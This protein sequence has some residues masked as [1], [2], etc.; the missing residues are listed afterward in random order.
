MSRLNKIK[1]SIATANNYGKLMVLI[2]LLVGIPLIILP[3]YPEEINYAPS[4]LIPSMLTVA[5]GVLTCYFMPNRDEQDVEW[6]SSIHKGGRTV[7]FIWIFASFIGSVPFIISREL[8]FIH[9][10]FESVSGWSTTGLTVADV[11]VMPHVFLFY[12]SFMQY[13]GGLGFILIISMIF[14]GKQAMNMYSAEGHLDRIK[15]NLRHTAQTIFVLYNGFLFI[16]IFLYVVFGMELFDAICHTM[17]A[18]ST[19]GFTTKAGSIGEYNS[20]PI[21]TVTIILMIIGCTNF[22]VLLL[23]VQGK[24]RQMFKISEVR[25]LVGVITVFVTLSAI[26]LVKET[27]VG[28]VEGVHDA[29]FGVVTI[30]STTGYSTMDYSSWPPFALGLAMLLMII[31]GSTGSTA[32][33]IKL[34]RTYLLIRITKNNIHKRFSARQVVT[35][36]SFYGL[37]GKVHIDETIVNDTIGFI[38]CYMAVLIF[39]TLA[40]T[41][42]EGCSLFDA[43]FEFASAFGTVGISN[44]LTNAGT[45]TAT[46]IIEMIG[47]ILGRLEIFIVMA[48]FFSIRSLK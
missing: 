29:F 10:L 45:K 17:S 27:G 15:P 12:R 7:L 33:G 24:F 22:G 30:F 43:M 35:A 21:E 28:I 14:Q 41:V 34:I 44:G 13:C 1:Q 46:L 4:F 48:G 23:L 11:T 5:I 36:P 40:I 39:G 37:Q 3:F 31:G 2:G 25:F 8:S 20:Y 32:G 18:L 47:M 9:A 16:G 42:T 26:S 6:V 19:A 38:S